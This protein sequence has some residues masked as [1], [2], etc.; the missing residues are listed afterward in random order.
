VELF[1]SRYVIESDND[2][3]IPGISIDISYT[4]RYRIEDRTIMHN[5]NVLNIRE[6]EEFLVGEENI[7]YILSYNHYINGINREFYTYEKNTLAR[8]V[9]DDVP[10]V[11]IALDDL[12]KEI[13]YFINE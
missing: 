6:N 12:Q 2:N 13:D 9:N 1:K 4:L 5:I 11:E 8:I 7:F 10:I 3:N